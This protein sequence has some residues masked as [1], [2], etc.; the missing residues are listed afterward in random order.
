M[1]TTIS[2][3]PNN[4]IRLRLHPGREANSRDTAEHRWAKLQANLLKLRL[5]TGTLSNQLTPLPKPEKPKE[6]PGW[7]TLSCPRDFSRRA[8]RTIQRI[9]GVV[10][11]KYDK[12]DCLFLTGTLPGS[13]YESMEAFAKWSGYA[14]DRIGAWLRNQKIEYDSFHVWELQRRGALHI[15]M[16]IATKDQSLYKFV[17]ENWKAH[18]T[19]ILNDI[20]KKE[21][22]DMWA[23]S[24]GGSWKDSQEVIQTRALP[25][26]KSVSAYLSK[27]ATKGN[28]HMA[29]SKGFTVKFY[30]SRWWGCSRALRQSLDELTSCHSAE[31]SDSQAYELRQKLYFIQD[32]SFKSYSY[33]DKFGSGYNYV[34]YAHPGSLDSLLS[35]VR[36]LVPSASPIRPQRRLADLA[37]KSKQDLEEEAELF[38]L[39]NGSKKSRHLLRYERQKY[40][41]ENKWKIMAFFEYGERFSN[42]AEALEQLYK[43][44]EA[45]WGED[46]PELIQIL[47]EISE[48]PEN[49]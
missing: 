36:S 44:W 13:T 25:V 22:I 37:L 23:R 34:F 46:A 10:D 31:I 8:R 2:S 19:K 11:T 15:H 40:L 28:T 24:K 45:D 42:P 17:Q 30:P 49:Y 32:Q 1:K 6:K 41:S 39:I 48:L 3:Y 16:L 21:N 14:T 4:E 47:R 9:G 29:K 26:E 33:P 27:Y 20:G 35:S 7:G 43:D 18:W 12:S 38:E 5:E